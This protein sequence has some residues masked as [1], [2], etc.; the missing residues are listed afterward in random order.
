VIKPF[1]LIVCIGC[2]IAAPAIDTEWSSAVPS[3]QRAALIKRLDAYLKANRSRDWKKLYSLI[4]DVAR[5]GADRQIF[6]AKMTAAHGRDFANDPDLLE[7][8]PA[9]TVTGS[10]YDIYGCAKAQR[11]GRDFN[12]IALIHAVLDHNEWFFSGWR[13]T[14]FP[15]EPC[16]A[17][18]NPS[19]ETPGPM[20]WNQPMEEL[21]SPAGLPFHIDAPK[22]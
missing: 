20:E 9:R 3:E 15:N 18:S 11:E 6:I 2:V 10:G 22:K 13:F 12:G 4:S 21:R 1:S 8:Q 5:G 17:L 7:F 16:K 14:A 19:W